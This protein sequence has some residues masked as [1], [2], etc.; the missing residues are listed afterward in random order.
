MK[1]YEVYQIHIGHSRLN[2]IGKDFKTVKEAE[3]AA[4]NSRSYTPDAYYVIVE[5]EG[6]TM[7][8]KLFNE[9]PTRLF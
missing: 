4:K 7:K 8:A 6:T 3:N 5:R 1:E 2:F 9:D